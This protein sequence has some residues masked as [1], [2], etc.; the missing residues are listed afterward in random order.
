[1]LTI[2]DLTYRIG[3]R[4]LLDQASAQ[5]PTGA[6]VGLIG[7]NGAGK[8]TLLALIRGASQPDGGAIELPRG[9]RIAY[10][11]QEAP[12]GAAT[13]LAEVLAADRERAALLEERDA[14]PSHP[15][16]AEIEARL[17]EIDAYSAPSR[18]ARILAGLGLDEVMQRCQLADL[19]G[20]WR[21]RVALAA[22]LFAEPDL[23]L[24]DEPTNHLDLEA[25]LWLERFLRNYHRSLIL[26]SHD[27]R[28][29]NAVTTL[30]LHLRNGKLTLYSGGFDAYLRSRSDAERR[31]GTLAR[32]QHLE[33]QRLQA[34]VDRFRYKASKARQAQSRLK[35]LARLEPIVLPVEESPARIAFP[36]P[37]QLSPPLIALEGVAVGYGPGKPVLSRLDLR[38]DPDDRIALLGANGNGKTTLARLLAGRLAPMAGRVT[39]PPRLASGFF[40]QHQIEEMRP[41]ESGFDHLSTLMPGRMPEAVRAQLGRFGFSQEK[42][43]VAVGELSGGE[44]ARLN[45]AL[46]THEA[47]ALLILD[48]PTNHLD[49]ETREA[50][51]R[52]INDFAGAVVVVS[53]DRHLLELV[54]DRLWLVANG[55]VRPFD[56][57]LDDYEHQ[58]LDSGGSGRVSRSG[59]DRE[60]SRDLRGDPRGDPGRDARRRARR[61]A[62]ERRRELEPLR[63]I[64]RRAEERIAK[65]T[66]E[67]DALDRV[68]ARPSGSHAMPE[69]LAGSLKRRAELARLIAAAENEWL[70]AEES[71]EREGE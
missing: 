17:V 34:F 64:A 61:L 49:L 47:P 52:A 22:V 51:V 32:Q 1:M 57:D 16:A 66:E 69:T 28:F 2:S 4:T 18:A 42:A 55:T 44:R 23:L 15:R 24:L 8:S 58:V 33:R 19:S 13:P 62:A 29:L 25:A 39:R 36:E 30:T 70:A 59:E 50:L 41:D 40:A 63:R 12:G 43:F 53:H 48:E 9:C 71:I 56:G 27:R 21:M 65:L 37:L 5:L 6:R 11:A 7:R 31:L 45:L 26:V 60:P 68:L 14:R 20:G 3:A 54:A 35:A 67:R 38:L 46:V 10:L